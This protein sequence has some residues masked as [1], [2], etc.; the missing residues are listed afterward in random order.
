MARTLGRALLSDG[1]VEDGGPFS[2]FDD[3]ANAS[4]AATFQSATAGTE[5]IANAMAGGAPPPV[6]VVDDHSLVVN[7]W[8]QIADWISYPT[9][10]SG[11]AYQFYDSGTDPGSGQFWTPSGSYQ[12]PETILTVAA[13]DLANVWIGGATATGTDQMLIRAFDGANWSDWDPF[14]FTAV[15]NSPSVANVA[16][17][18]L[19]VGHWDR[20][21]NFFS[22]SDANGDVTTM[23]QFSDGG[24]DPGSAQFWTPSGGYQAANTVLTATPSELHDVWIGGASATGT[25]TI[26]IR[27]FDGTDWGDW[28]PFELTSQPNTAPHVQGLDE[29]VIIGRWATMYSVYASDADHDPITQVQFMDLSDDPGGSRIWTQDGGYQPVGVPLTVAVTPSYPGNPNYDV[30]S[31]WVG[32]A[33]VAGTETMMVR[34]FDGHD[35]SAWDTFDVTAH[36]NTNVPPVVQVH[37]ISLYLNQ[38]VAPY[39]FV[40]TYDPD[41]YMGNTPTLQFYDDG[42]GQGS[43]HFYFDPTTA[44]QGQ[45]EQAAGTII[46]PRW[47]DY[48]HLVG[49]SVPGTETMYVRAFDGTDWS[50]WDPFV[51]TTHA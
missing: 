30:S 43:A 20:I 29:S 50:S 9:G 36:V 11:V 49:G 35:W 22:V 51:V 28:A 38:S 3:A 15:A 23:Y 39:T 45:G 34:A 4:G 1:S 10:G 37:D 31:V 27:A 32:G 24:T 7:H 18:S 12:A 48:F 44:P 21:E 2:S 17:H 41:T 40:H 8:A 25:E 46:Q 47:I 26:S 13:A 19:A 16:D 14:N 6:P 5:T 33:T 42:F